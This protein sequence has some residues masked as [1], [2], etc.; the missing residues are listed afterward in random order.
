MKLDEKKEDGFMSHQ[1]TCMLAGLVPFLN[2]VLGLMMV[3]GIVQY[4]FYVGTDHLKR[5]IKRFIIKQKRKKTKRRLLKI[6][7]KVTG[8]NLLIVDFLLRE[9]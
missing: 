4:Y 9:L 6:R 2:L 1:R 3:I 7:S 5:R 8:Q